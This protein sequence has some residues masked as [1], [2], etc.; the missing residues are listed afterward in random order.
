MRGISW[1]DVAILWFGEAEWQPTFLMDSTLAAWHTCV[2]G[3]AIVLL[4][5]LLCVVS[6]GHGLTFRLG[7]SELVFSS[8]HGK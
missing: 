4:I 8:L 7:A 2:S 5:I 6:F 3:S 1:Y